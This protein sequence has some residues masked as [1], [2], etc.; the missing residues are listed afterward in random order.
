MNNEIQKLSSVT[1]TDNCNILNILNSKYY[2]SKEYPSKHYKL[3]I[4][5]KNVQYIFLFKICSYCLEKRHNIRGCKQYKANSI[6]KE[7]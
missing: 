5:K 2:K 3:L 7:N 4:K 1:I 6:N